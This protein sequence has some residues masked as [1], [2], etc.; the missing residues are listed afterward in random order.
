MKSSQSIL[1]LL[2]ICNSG[3]FL[4][5]TGKIIPYLTSPFICLQFSIFRNDDSYGKSVLTR[6]ICLFMYSAFFGL[7]LRLFLQTNMSFYAC[8]VS[9]FFPYICITL[10]YNRSSSQLPNILL[11]LPQY[12]SSYYLFASNFYRINSLRHFAITCVAP[13]FLQQM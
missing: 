12:F 5:Y 13:S 1:P 6:K 11:Y 3:Q 2:Y 7:V 9:S 4:D 8:C 10:T